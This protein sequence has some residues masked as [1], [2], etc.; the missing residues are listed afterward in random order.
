MIRQ[1]PDYDA[2]GTVPTEPKLLKPL[3]GLNEKPVS[4]L[5]I[6]TEDVLYTLGNKI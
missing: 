2:L 6:V 3:T 4:K 5:A 1:M